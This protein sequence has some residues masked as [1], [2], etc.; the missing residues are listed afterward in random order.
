MISRLKISG[1]N[2]ENRVRVTSICIGAMLTL[3]KTKH[4][5]R[6]DTCPTVISRICAY[7]KQV[8]T[9]WKLIFWYKV[10]WPQIHRTV[11]QFST[12]QTP[13]D[14]LYPGFWLVENC[15]IVRWICY[16]WTLY[17]KINFQPIRTCLTRAQFRG[18][19]VGHVWFRC[20]CIALHS[21]ML[22]HLKR[23][24]CLHRLFLLWVE[25]NY[26]LLSRLLHGVAYVSI[27]HVRSFVCR[28]VPLF[29][30]F[31]PNNL[32]HGSTCMR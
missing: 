26:T 7:V 11:E 27:L 9:G 18:M 2:K 16:H 24:C 14:I 28:S 23:K 25:S 21:A 17:P 3:C 13:G 32:S 4:V 15:S 30:R 8:L 19:T 12:N 6:N 22:T 29:V 31:L 5:Q 1:A 20:T 10:Q